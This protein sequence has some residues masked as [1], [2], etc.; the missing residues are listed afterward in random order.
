MS[1]LTFTVSNN[2]RNNRN[3]SR[4]NRNNSRKPFCKVCFDAGKPESEFTCHFVKDQ[5]GPSGKVVCPTLLSTECRYCRKPGHFKSHCPALKQKQATEE[6]NRTIHRRQA[7]EQRRQ[8]INNG[9]WATAGKPET[10]NQSWLSKQTQ[11]RVEKEVVFAKMQKQTAPKITNRFE[12]DSD[13]D[14]EE[15]IMDYNRPS[16]GKLVP[17]QG[18]WQRKAPAA[19]APAA[20]A[21]AKPSDKILK[22]IKEIEA[23]LAEVREEMDDTSAPASTNWADMCDKEEE[24]ALELKEEV[25]VGQL[26]RLRRKL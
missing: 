17:L 20:A 21:G 14:D 18:V 10:T 1:A 9:G 23:Q 2:S 25:L 3:N 16:V 8:H 13:S 4:N 22:R 7:Q 24:K 5:P 11:E 26:E 15:I 12:I 19:A 6:Y